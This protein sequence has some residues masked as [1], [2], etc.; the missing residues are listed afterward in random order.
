ML[1]IVTTTWLTQ[2]FF[3]R[4]WKYDI[5]GFFGV[6]IFNSENV[7]ATIRKKNKRNQ[8]K[9]LF[10]IGWLGDTVHRNKQV[11]QSDL[12]FDKHKL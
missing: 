12:N 10:G 5:Q 3:N 1:W 8:E 11:W 7:L 2:I 4:A 6:I 9:V